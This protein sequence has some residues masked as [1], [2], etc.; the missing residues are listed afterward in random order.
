MIDWMRKFVHV[1]NC[2]FTAEVAAAAEK[3]GT[4]TLLVRSFGL[5][6][7]YAVLRDL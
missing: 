2:N 3:S 5:F 4:A 6:P 7:P 1:I